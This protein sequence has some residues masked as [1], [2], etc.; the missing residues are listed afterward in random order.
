MKLAALKAAVANGALQLGCMT[1][2]RTALPMEA[3]ATLT[4]VTKVTDKASN[5]KLRLLGCVCNALKSEMC[6]L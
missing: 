3:L 5:Q 6:L 1:L 2:F 4:K